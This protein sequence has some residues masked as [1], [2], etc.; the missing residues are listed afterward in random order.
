MA[1]RE[2]APDVEEIAV[3]LIG[4]YH[5]HIREHGALIVYRKSDQNKAS[6]GRSVDAEMSV[7]SGDTRWAMSRWA[8]L[9]G[10]EPDFMLTVY[11]AMWD[12]YTPLQRKACVDRELCRIVAKTVQHSDGE[13]TVLKLQSY[14]VKG[15][16]ENITR[17]GVWQTPYK[18]FSA[19]SKQ[20]SLFSEELKIDEKAEA[21]QAADA[22][23][24]TDG[25]AEDGEGE[26]VNAEDGDAEAIEQVRQ[27][28]SRRSRG[29]LAVVGD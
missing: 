3:G 25:T 11:G 10:S 24:Q 19:A 18:R 8:E 28:G 2:L 29:N 20:P 21:Q 13:T 16:P 6:G 14:E 23:A 22:A 7:V 27:V 26:P 17:F 9:E 15:F 5:P 4:E 12:G 1:D